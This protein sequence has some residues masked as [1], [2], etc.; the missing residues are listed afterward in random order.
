MSQSFGSQYV[1][2]NQLLMQQAAC[3]HPL[4]SIR[5]QTITIGCMKCGKH[6]TL[7][8]YKAVWARDAKVSPPLKGS[9]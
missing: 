2:M 8:E 5:T 4:A 1:D 9:T 3:T 6:L 7:E